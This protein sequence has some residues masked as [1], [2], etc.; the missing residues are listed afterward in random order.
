MLSNAVLQIVLLYHKTREDTAKRK[1]KVENDGSA[2]LQNFDSFKQISRFLGLL[3][4]RYGEKNT[5]SRK[6]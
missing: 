1:R 5:R 3:S 4:L 2:F 6:R